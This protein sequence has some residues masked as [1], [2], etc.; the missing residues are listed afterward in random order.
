MAVDEPTPETVTEAVAFL[1]AQGYIEDLQLCPLGIL[2]AGHEEPH[3]FEGATVDHTFRFEGASDPGDEAIVL[4]VSCGQW[5]TKGVVVSAYGPD[6][7]PED[8]AILTALARS[9][10]G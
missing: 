3:P 6:A 10:R 2:R 9:A 8:T 7:D 5:G 4:G 1:A